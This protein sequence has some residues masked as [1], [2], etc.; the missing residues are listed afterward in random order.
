MH[1]SPQPD[2][3][4]SVRQIA[5]AVEHLAM[6][7]PLT[8]VYNN[9]FIRRLMMEEM[10][11]SRRYHRPLS[12]VLCQADQ[13]AAIRERYGPVAGDSLLVQLA[14]RLHH[15]VRAVDRLGR[16]G[17][18]RFSLLL[19]ETSVEQAISIVQRL[20]QAIKE[21]PLYTARNV[22]HLTLSAA[23]VGEIE[24]IPGSLD[25]ILV[26]LNYSLQGAIQAGGDLI[27]VGPA[28]ALN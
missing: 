21:V 19:P 25:N 1:S 14:D 24:W 22:H 23:V 17:P 12:M 4:L 15:H 27:I 18:D 7:D 26:E 2:K 20:A 3:L 13:M 11:R 6:H 8:G 5:V 9:R 28:P 10:L 16:A